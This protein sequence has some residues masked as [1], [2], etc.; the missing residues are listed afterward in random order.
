M[1]LARHVEANDTFS[2]KRCLKADMKFGIQKSSLRTR[3]S[4]RPSLKRYIR[5]SLGFKSLVR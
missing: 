2:R 3:I 1:F 5:H 4:A